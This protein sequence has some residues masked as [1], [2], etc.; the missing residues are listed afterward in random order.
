M[1]RPAIATAVVAF[2]LATTSCAADR[3]APTPSAA[4]SPT[5]AD[6]APVVEVDELDAESITV[7]P[8]GDFLVSSGDLVWVSGVEP[9]IVAFDDTMAPVFEVRS[10]AVWA[11]LEFGHGFVWSSEAPDG[12]HATSLLRIDPATGT[13]TRFA[14]PSPGVP[15]ESSIAVTDDAV[16]AI[17]PG[18]G[19]GDAWTLVGLDPMS[20][21]GTRRIGLGDEPVAAVRGGFGSLW[22]TRPSGMLARI[23]PETGGAQAEVELPPGSTFLAIGPDAVWIMN[24]GGGVS[25]VDPAT[26]RVV[27]TIPA[28][29]N[30]IRGGDIAATADA[31]WVQANGFLGVQVDPRTNTVV[32]R[33]RPGLGSGGIAI[34]ADGSVWITAHDVHTLYRI[35]SE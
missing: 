12:V 32:R 24:Q 5:G 17:V 1:R 25:R 27:A 9:G 16:W 21:T 14:L 19:S 4:P 11:A 15:E 35:A 8:F 26:N 30:G 31:V 2:L 22:V 3:A 33:I 6:S 23:D 7:Q 28:N 29:P 18:D 34:A 13:A 20:G 10:G